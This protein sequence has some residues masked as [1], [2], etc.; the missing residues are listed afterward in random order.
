MGHRTLKRVPL[1]F[2]WPLHKVWDGY[3]NPF[4]KPCPEDQKTCFNGSTAGSAWLAAIVRL[5]CCASEDA[6]DGG[7]RRERGGIWPH[8]YLQRLETAPRYECPKPL[9][10]TGG[11]SALRKWHSDHGVVPPS[12]DLRDLVVALCGRDLGNHHDA[13]DSWKIQSAI[14]KAAGLSE[15]WGT[16][17]ICHGRCLDPSVQ[18]EYE[19]WEET[20]PPKGDGWQLWETC[21]EGSP[22][23]PVFETKEQLADWCVDNAT[24]FADFKATRE[25]WLRMFSTDGGCD[26]GS[27]VI[28][29]GGKFGAAVDFGME[30]GSDADQ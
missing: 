13:I 8:P 2:S 9:V 24:T 6:A 25:Q 29:K 20:E 27:M 7:R 16:C 4:W 18:A 1:D 28:M 19:A 26:V 15:D 10:D 14:V 5:L 22:V 11:L 23:S 3:L 21:S 12:A 30:T 17:P